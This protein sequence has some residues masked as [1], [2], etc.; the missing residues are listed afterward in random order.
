MKWIES[1]H[2]VIGSRDL[3]GKMNSFPSIGEQNESS[4]Y[5]LY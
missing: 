2:I 5:L 4:I 3:N 1:D